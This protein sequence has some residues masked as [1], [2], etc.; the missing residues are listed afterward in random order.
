MRPLDSRR[1]RY[2]LLGALLALGAPA[3]HLVLRAA[4]ARSASPAWLATELEALW[5]SYVYLTISTT[6]VFAV[7]GWLLGSKEDLLNARATTDA[8]TKLANRRH[9]DARLEEEVRRAERYATPLALL[10]IDVDNLK[11]LNARGGHE[12]GDAA[13]RAVGEALAH[14][15]RR[16]DLAARIGGDE[17]AV[18]APMTKAEEALELAERIRATL[19]GRRAGTFATPTVSLGIAGLQRGEADPALLFGRADQALFR[20]KDLGRDRAIL[21]PSS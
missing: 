17:F 8:L 16:S 11:A 9:F 14:I 13:L 7:L 20:A 10:L 18:I 1:K 6:I 19:R 21:A 15:V 5:P 3:G 2:P 12:G 4:L